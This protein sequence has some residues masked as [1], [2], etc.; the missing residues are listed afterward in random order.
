MEQNININERITEIRNK[1]KAYI[2]DYNVKMEAFEKEMF[3]LYEEK[4]SVDNV[5][6]KLLC[7]DITIYDNGYD[8]KYT[9]WY[10]LMKQNGFSVQKTLNKLF[11]YNNNYKISFNFFVP[12]SSKVKLN[13]GLR[14]SG[15]TL[16]IDIKLNN[17]GH[18]EISNI[19]FSDNDTDDIYFEKLENNPHTFSFNEDIEKLIDRIVFETN[20]ESI[21][22]LI[23]LCKDAFVK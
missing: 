4:Y 13:Y 15:K 20:Q 16:N 12:Y 9:S 21:Y 3:K 8:E 11:D 19:I 23:N 10:T 1:R 17:S 22:G 5:I 18:Y 2:D 6:N 7:Y 14:Y